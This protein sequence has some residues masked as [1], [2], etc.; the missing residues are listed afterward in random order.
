MPSKISIDKTLST[1]WP[2]LRAFP[3]SQLDN[4]QRPD[5]TRW[6][7][8]S[9]SQPVGGVFK[10]TSAPPAACGVGDRISTTTSR[11]VHSVNNDKEAV[12]SPVST[13]CQVATKLCDLHKTIEC[14]SPAP[15]HLPQVNSTATA[16]FQPCEF[17]RGCR[18]SARLS[19]D[20]ERPPALT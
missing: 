13:K 1:P 15:S 16:T 18:D 19:N 8:S 12:G 17:R 9:R 6:P 4:L 3:F 10:M 14:S 2:L 7:S 20:L 5:Q 11:I